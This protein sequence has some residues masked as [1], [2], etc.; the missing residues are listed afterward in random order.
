[1]KILTILLC[2]LVLLPL[3][4]LCQTEM[5]SS[6][7][8]GTPEFFYD[9]V[10]V[11]SNEAGLSRL[12]IY[13]EIPYDELQFL[14]QDKYFKAKYEVSVV[15]F[16]DDGEQVDGKIWQEEVVVD[17]YELTNSRKLYSFTHNDCHLKPNEYR[18]SIG[19][20][21]MD[22]KKTGNRKSVFRLRDFN[23]EE[24]SVSDLTLTD[25]VG[26]DSLGVKSIHP[27]VADCIRATGTELYCYFEIYSKDT[28]ENKFEISY[29]IK[30]YKSQKVEERKY[31]RLKDGSR[32]M[33]Y[34]KIDKNK[35]S[36]GKYLIEL[37]VKQG[38]YSDSI[39]KIFIVRW[40]GIPSTVADLSSA[41]Q[42]LK[43]IAKQEEID[44]IKN[45]PQSEQ[46][47][48]FEKFWEKR[49]P[50]PGTAKNE[51][52]DEY[53]NRVEYSNE[54]FSAFKEGWRTDMGMIYII[55]GPPNDIE[56]HPFERGYKPFEIWYYYHINRQFIF[57]D[58]TGFG[59]YR[60]RNPYWR[61]WQE[62]IYY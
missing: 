55:F 25:N 18:I 14:K 6:I 32:T 9:I 46:L 56:R 62:G 31:L 53:Y 30:N 40:T 1:M 35:L 19:L 45:A 22:S 41:V 57:V 33:E 13:I 26:I 42:Q 36:H 44:N 54:N 39:K 38:K 37:S 28:N 59:E 21:D 12:N 5:R 16:D 48:K 50:T 23:K 49:D 34:F 17:R 27:Q 10:N 47:E 4:I 11:M 52:M 2:L 60:L 58:E 61:N 8:E 3:Q 43:Y 15:I 51:L 20:M 24:L 7:R 29:F